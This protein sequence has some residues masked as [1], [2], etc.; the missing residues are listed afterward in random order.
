MLTTYREDTANLL[1][2]PAAPSALY[3]TD[4]IDR[5][6]NIARGQLAGEGECIRA[7]GTI[8]T[9][10]GQREYLFSALNLGVAGTTGIAGAIHVRRVALGIA[11]GQ[12]WLTPRPWPWFDL[13]HMNNVVP[14]NGVPTV[15]AQY[16]QGAATMSGGSN[17]S[18]SFYV[19]PP[20]DAVYTLYC[21]CVCYPVTLVTDD[22]IEAIPYLWTDSVPFFA[23]YYALLS[24]QTSARQDDA[25]RMFAHY[26][27]FVERARKAS[28]PSVGR[29]MY[30][31]AQDPAQV[32][33]LGLPKS[34]G[35]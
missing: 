21:D 15:W 11:D 9:V 26:Q 2:S 28:N 34:G 16:R 29:W 3:S 17:V 19:D 18:G 14:Q 33:K 22:T 7:I 12:R 5:W 4:N 31:Q 30:E 6:I 10:I 23:S 20:P 27:T 1:Q 24:S 35:G 25:E 8:P 32:N 13:Y